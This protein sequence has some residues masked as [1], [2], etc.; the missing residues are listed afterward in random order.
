[1]IRLEK[2]SSPAWRGRGGNITGLS[3][4]GAELPGKRL[5]ILKETVPQST[6]IAVLWNPV[7]PGYEFRK[8]LLNNLT[9]VARALELQLH[10]MELRSADELD[11]AFAAMTR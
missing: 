2:G 8:P 4:L 6:R 1:M 11:T 5:E 10:V 9:V 3:F 7:G